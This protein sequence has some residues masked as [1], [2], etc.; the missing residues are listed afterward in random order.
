DANGNFNGSGVG[1]ALQGVDF[2]LA[3]L[4]DNDPAVTTPKTYFALK[5]SGSAQVLGIPAITLTGTLSIEANG[6]TDANGARAPPI[7]FTQL[8]GGG[9]AVP[10]GVST[11]I[12]LD[13]SGPVLKATGTV[14]LAIDGF[15]YVTGAFALDF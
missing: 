3:L 8:P 4:K 6:A 15:A 5:G 2:G 7:D 10:T 14:T 12:L 1:V 13:Y 11:S 9:L